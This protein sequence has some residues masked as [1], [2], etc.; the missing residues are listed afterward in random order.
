M[1]IKNQNFSPISKPQIFDERNKDLSLGG[2]DVTDIDYAEAK[3]QQQLQKLAELGK[4][5][6]ISKKSFILVDRSIEK[7]DKKAPSQN[8]GKIDKFINNEGFRIN[9]P[10]G[11]YEYHTG[12]L[13]EKCE[14]DAIITQKNSGTILCELHNKENGGFD[15]VQCNETIASYNPE[16]GYFVD[17]DAE[18]V[19]KMAPLLDGGFAAYYMPSE[20]PAGEYHPKNGTVLNGWG[21]I[22]AENVTQKEAHTIM[23]A[24]LATDIAQKF[25]D[26]LRRESI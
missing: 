19:I 16:T 14:A 18:L 25:D 12:E 11:S 6:I 22:V 5:S 15:V 2:K 1:E 20:A 13:A 3:M 23:T 8:A 17:K 21:D 7:Y 10:T 24:I 26:K 9:V 4:S